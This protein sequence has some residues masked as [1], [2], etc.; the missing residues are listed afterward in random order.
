MLNRSDVVTS[1][2][3]TN[4]VVL[5]ATIGFTQQ[6]QQQHQEEAGD[7]E[8]SISPSLS[9]LTTNLEEYDADESQLEDS[10]L[11]QQEEGQKTAPSKP[12]S[13]T[14]T[15]TAK[16]EILV[17]DEKA[18][19]IA[20]AANGHEEN[21]DHQIERNSEQPFVQAPP[22]ISPLRN[23]RT[24]SPSQQPQP[25]PQQLIIL[26]S[27]WLRPATSQPLPPFPSSTPSTSWSSSIPS[28]LHLF[29]TISFFIGCSVYVT[30]SLTRLDY[31][32]TRDAIEEESQLIVWWYYFGA[33]TC[34]GVCG[35]LEILANR[36]KWIR[37]LYSIMVVAS[38]F[39]LVSSLSIRRGN[40]HTSTILNSISVHFFALE[41]IFILVLNAEDDEANSEDK[42]KTASSRAQ[43]QKQQIQQQPVD[44]L[45]IVI[46]ET[47]E[48][49]SERNDPGR[50]MKLKK[51]CMTLCCTSRS[52]FR[53][54][55]IIFFVGTILDVI[56][57]YFYIHG[58]GTSVAEAGVV[59]AGLWFLS[60][61]IYLF[62]TLYFFYHSDLGDDPIVESDRHNLDV[63]INSD[64]KAATR[65]S[66]FENSSQAPFDESTNVNW[67]Y[68]EI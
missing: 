34:F 53:I 54:G 43:R 40:Y 61:L 62:L 65:K 39:G 63:E 52:W 19:E 2:T 66:S 13:I 1:P 60:G 17:D 26:S 46:D 32:R 16:Q 18:V 5:V 49:S 29:S 67:E 25:V 47:I 68:G 45:S 11:T 4:D 56:L 41:A 15:T 14:P 57:S 12:S 22:P 10:I 9:T 55:D 51:H 58:A 50:T 38:T 44:E 7:E 30:F 42:D 23:P 8:S 33:T 3:T 31:Y 64:S 20:V 24:E 21:N 59:A 36:D 48:Y 27:Q 28:W 37:I 35:L 6:Q